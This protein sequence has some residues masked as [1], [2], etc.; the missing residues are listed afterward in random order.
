MHECLAI[1]VAEAHQRGRGM[2]T[3][4]G[5]R[6]REVKRLIIRLGLDRLKQRMRRN[7]GTA[8]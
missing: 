5:R 1:I 6:T 4:G 3:E 8:D 2:A 7:L